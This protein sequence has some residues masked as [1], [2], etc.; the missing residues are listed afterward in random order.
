MGIVSTETASFAWAKWRC[1]GGTS[2]TT[3]TKS[4]N[5]SMPSAK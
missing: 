1:H 3:N 2:A 4:A 5:A